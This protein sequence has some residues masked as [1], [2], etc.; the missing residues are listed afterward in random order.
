MS[1]SKISSKSF[2]GKLYSF[3]LHCFSKLLS[4]TIV[5]SLLVASVEAAG[6]LR[7][8]PA[9]PRYFVDS[10]GQPVYLTGAHVSNNLVDR[11]DKVQIDF[12]S[13]LDV[14]YYYQQNFVRLRAPEQATWTYESGERLNYFFDQT[15]FFLFKI[16]ISAHFLWSIV[17]PLWR[18]I[19]YPR[20]VSRKVKGSTGKKH[21]REGG[22]PGRSAS[23]SDQ[24]LKI[25]S[26]K[27]PAP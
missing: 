13:Y 26:K 12:S 23:S 5:T 20:R 24:R 22:S 17:K 6:P 8:N 25:S 2:A 27:K 21:P 14:Q 15:E 16:C 11:S 10:N 1:E 18:S 19:K 7:V 4:A 3:G 9:N